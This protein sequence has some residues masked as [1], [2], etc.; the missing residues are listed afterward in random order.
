VLGIAAG[1]AGIA[2]AS[3]A[4]VSGN[5]EKQKPRP[6]E[7]AT[8]AA[9]RCRAGE[10]RLG[11]SRR[12]YAVVLTRQAHVRRRPGGAVLVTLPK[13]RRSFAGASAG[14]VP[15]VALALAERVESD[16]R[17]SWYRIEL[18]GEAGLPSGR[19]GYV[20]A[21][22]VALIAVR[23]RIRVDLS[24]R[25]LTLYRDGRR[26]L[27]VPVAIGAP[28][29]PTPRGR[30]FVEERI[31][32]NDPSG[33]FGGAAIAI[34]AFSKVLPGWPGGGPIAI[35]GTNEPWSIGKAF[36]DGCIRIGARNLK[37]LFAAVEPGTPVV[38][39]S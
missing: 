36:S 3:Y 32:V 9:P 26:V 37:R 34:S 12:A 23:T 24:Q 30:F 21:G 6:G 28:A 8:S 31:R 15:T 5:G 1:A 7:Q 13:R 38:I 17:P 11:S 22:S 2:L 14:R 20:R 29:T 18:P 39:G 33:P 27:Q 16:C 4:L 25:R 19:Y 35:H 10:L